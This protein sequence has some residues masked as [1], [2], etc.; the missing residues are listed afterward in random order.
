MY[1]RS[2]TFF[3]SPPLG[4]PIYERRIIEKDGV[5]VEAMVDAS[6]CDISLNPELY[7]VEV[8][9]RTGNLLPVATDICVP[10]EQVI[11]NGI[12]YINNQIKD[13]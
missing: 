7:T 10:S 11:E 13:E 3:S 12:E 1:T 9:M 8:A 6:M 5:P 2:K 4:A